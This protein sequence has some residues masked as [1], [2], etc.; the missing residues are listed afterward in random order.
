MLRTGIFRLKQLNKQKICDVF[1]KEKNISILLYE[2]LIN[3]CN[4]NIREKYT[5]IILNR[6]T[7]HSQIFKRTYRNRFNE[8]DLLA[9]TTILNQS[10]SKLRIHD[11]AISD[12]RASYFFLEN[13]LKKMSIGVYHATDLAVVYNLL[14]HKTSSGSYFITD[15]N[16]KICEITFPPFVWNFSR[17]EGR[18]YFINNILKSLLK[19]RYNHLLKKGA[20]K[21]IKSIYI[22]D[23]EFRKLTESNDKITLFDYNLFEKPI[24]TYDVVRAM[25][26]LHYDYFSSDQLDKILDNIYGSMEPGGLF[27]EGSNEEAA[28]PVEG[29]IYKKSEKGFKLISLADKPSRILQQ[30]LEFDPIKNAAINSH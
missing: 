30:V 25:N 4:S 16:N 20:V 15:K 19:H 12:G 6:F 10:F 8:F 5:E 9:V 18:L 21:H 24:Y 7:S 11:T 13:V 28:S 23:K 29:A 3:D 2:D 22:I 26:I 14:K 17:I 27:I 1:G